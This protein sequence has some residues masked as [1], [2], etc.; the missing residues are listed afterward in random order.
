MQMSFSLWRGTQG[1]TGIPESNE[2]M[3]GKSLNEE[4]EPR[5]EIII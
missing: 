5:N 3:P 1:G 4:T 2:D